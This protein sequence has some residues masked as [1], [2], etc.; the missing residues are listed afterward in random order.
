MEVGAN[1][2]EEPGRKPTWLQD[3]LR[4]FNF[5]AAMRERKQIREIC[6]HALD[7]YERAAVEKPYASKRERYA[8]IVETLVGYDAAK[9]RQALRRAEESFAAWPVARP[10]SFRDVIQY[11]AV[12]DYLKIDIAES[13]VRSRVVDFAIEIVAEMIPARL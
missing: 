7:L 1:N 8:H 3:T 2:P 13:G 12:T 6:L 10:L 4:Q 5:V 11:V 9:A